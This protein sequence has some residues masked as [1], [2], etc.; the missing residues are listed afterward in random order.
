MVRLIRDSLMRYLTLT[1]SLVFLVCCSARTDILTVSETF[2]EPPRQA[3]P[4]VWWHWMFGYVS[5]DGILKDLSWMDRVGIAGFHQFDAG[6]LGMA[7][8]ADVQYPYFSDGWKEMFGYALHVADSLGM[9][10]TIA[11]APGWSST[12]GRWVTPQNAMKKL[13]WRVMETD[14]GEINIKLPDLYC[15]V[16]QFQDWYQPNDRIDVEPYGDDLAVLAVRMRDDDFSAE[17]QVLSDSEV[18]FRFDTAVTARAITVQSYRMASRPICTKNNIPENQRGKAQKDSPMHI[19]LSPYE[20]LSFNT[21]EVSDDGREWSVIKNLP[22]TE[23]PYLTVN[24]DAVTARCFRVRGERLT[25]AVLYG[26]G[27]IEHSEEQGA[28][29]NPKDLHEFHTPESACGVSD[30]DVSVIDLT[31]RMKGDGTLTCELPSGRW[32]IYRFGWSITGKVNHPANPEA[33][34]LEVDKLDPQA[35][36]D[37]FSTY[38]DKYRDASQGRMGSE[39]IQRLLIDSYEAG[40]QTWTPKMEEEFFRRRGYPLRRWLPVL[41]GEIIGG[42]T[43]SEGFLWDWRKTISELYEENYDRVDDMLAEYGL[44]GRYTESHEGGRA[45]CGDGMRVKKNA[46]IPMSAIWVHDTP[47]GSRI[48]SAVADIRESASV[49]HLYGRPIVAAESFTAEGSHQKAYTYTPEKLK[50]TADVALSAGLNRFVIHESAA[51]PGD[52]FL[53]GVGLFR[54]GQWFTRHET[55]AEWAR[56]WTDYL[57]RSCHLLQQ[58]HPV[59]DILCYYGE[60]SNVTSQWGGA[61]SDGLFHVPDGYEYDYIDPWSLLHTVRPFHGRLV[62][63]SGMSYSVLFISDD[64]TTMSVEVLERLAGFARAGIVICGKPPLRPAGLMADRGKFD[65]LVSDIWGSAGGRVVGTL[66]EAVAAAGIAPD[67]LAVRD[68]GQTGGGCCRKQDRGDGG[69]ISGDGPVCAGICPGMTSYRY[70]H[71][72]MKDA[73][74]WWVRNFDEPSGAGA[75][76]GTWNMLNGNGPDSASVMSFRCDRRYAYLF[77]PEDGSITD[78]SD[79]LSRDGGRCS[80]PL[81]V[82]PGKAVFAVLS[83]RKIPSA[84][85]GKKFIPYRSCGIAGPWSVDFKQKGG[86]EAHEEYTADICIT[87]SC[88]TVRVAAGTL[89]SWTCSS[90]P[91]V[92]YYSGIAEYT[93]SFDMEPPVSGVQI[94]MDLGEVREL[95]RV[96]VNGVDAGILWRAP[97]VTGDISGLLHVGENTLTVRVANTWV[98]RMI[99]DKQPGMTDRVTRVT[100]FYEASDPLLPSGLIG[101]V[102]IVWSE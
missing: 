40:S 35:W 68:S 51:Q 102:R 88:G 23:L 55:W 87:D 43:E 82:V 4:Y 101:P 30:R 99:G 66:P 26:A 42:V 97:F 22:A 15:T 33:T 32:R 19:G 72:V 34:G 7:R 92:R 14:G 11:S 80:L 98:N 17:G 73:D 57:A 18:L 77:D 79:L 75:G 85:P 1:I 89:P 64:C 49:A 38:L 24:F 6:G 76:S 78:W 9:D 29:T 54:Y 47:E 70:V 41:A 36:T 45:F 48:P 95:A 100:R 16:G 20:G 69:G 67:F 71:R 59:A 37:Y 93:A 8:A 25:G 52:D 12:G 60:D 13:E 90:D 56:P 39:G 44:R 86:S 53:P 5:R 50:Y 3:R 91:V 46:E 28:F 63:D 74:I 94:R 10:V 2:A 81:S 62:T 58:G 83:D 21:V 31:G 96:L 65:S 84:D 27:R 61:S